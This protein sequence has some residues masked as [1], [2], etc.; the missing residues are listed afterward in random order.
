MGPPPPHWAIKAYHSRLIIMIMSR[1]NR[2]VLILFGMWEERSAL[3]VEGPFD[4]YW[5]HRGG[6]GPT[7]ECGSQGSNSSP[8]WACFQRKTPPP[9]K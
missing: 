4:R 7:L 2:S 5:R 6:G 1:Y 3:A 9:L 8:S